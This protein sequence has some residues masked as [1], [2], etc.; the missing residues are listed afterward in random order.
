[1]IMASITVASGCSTMVWPARSGITTAGTWVCLG[2]LERPP[3]NHHHLCMH[4]QLVSQQHVDVV[5]GGR[6][7]DVAWGVPVQLSA[8]A[9]VAPVDDLFLPACMNQHDL[10]VTAKSGW[11]AG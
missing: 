1:M 10:A 9:K 8:D 3:L 7:L 11:R 6:A 2:F 4:Q 5:A